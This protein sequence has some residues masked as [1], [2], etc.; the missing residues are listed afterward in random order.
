MNPGACVN[1]LNLEGTHCTQPGVA[2]RLL[3]EWEFGDNRAFSMHTFERLSAADSEEQ[4][5][6]L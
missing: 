4:P 2:N 6:C 3:P 5:G 1:V